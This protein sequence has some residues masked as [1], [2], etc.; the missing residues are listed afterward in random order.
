MQ[1]TTCK[2]LVVELLRYAT[3]CM[4]SQRLQIF[5]SFCAALEPQQIRQALPSLL[6]LSSAGVDDATAKQ[7]A[8]CAARV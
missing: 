6:F 2:L 7:K 3:T 8:R 5:E 4:T 1:V